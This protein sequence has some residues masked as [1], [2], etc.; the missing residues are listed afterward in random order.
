MAV[1]S[2][3]IKKWGFIFSV[4]GVDSNVVCSY[5][6]EFVIY[7]T[8]VWSP[9]HHIRKRILLFL[10]KSR[11]LAK[12]MWRVMCV[13]FKI[14]ENRSTSDH[15]EELFVLLSYFRTLRYIFWN[16]DPQIESSPSNWL[17]LENRS[18]P[19]NG[20]VLCWYYRRVQYRTPAMSTHQQHDVCRCLFGGHHDCPLLPSVSLGGVTTNGRG[21]SRMLRCIPRHQKNPNLRMR[22]MRSEL[23]ILDEQQHF[24]CCWWMKLIN[25][26]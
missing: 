4:G 26:K 7:A 15:N 24:Y 19:N 18:I 14:V 6:D 1:K 2:T 20:D 21:I 11:N 9:A 8:V 16:M 22:T 10:L 13:N 12:N 3:K 25:V 5:N 23:L 17:S